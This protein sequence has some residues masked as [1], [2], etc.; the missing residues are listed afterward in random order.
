MGESTDYGHD[1]GE[2]PETAVIANAPHEAG[3]G[4][5]CT[6]KAAPRPAGKACC[7]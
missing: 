7:G 3:D 6:P 5:C 4:G 2:A 1:L